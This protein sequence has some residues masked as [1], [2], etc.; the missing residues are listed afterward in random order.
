MPSARTAQLT[1]FMLTVDGV[2][3][4]LLASSV[5]GDVSADVIEQPVDGS[6]FTTKHLGP[7]KHEDFVV[8]FGFEMASPVYDWIAATW[9]GNFARKD[10]SV[11]AVD[12]SMNVKSEQQFTNALLTKT[13]IPALDAASKDAGS[14]TVAISP[15]ATRAAAGS[16]KAPPS[17]GKARRFPASAFRL[18]LDGLDCSHVTKI[19]SFTVEVQ[20]S[21]DA[22]DGL[23]DVGNEPKGID[24]PNLRVTMSDGPA[25]ATW[26]S[27]FTDFVLDGKNEEA[28]EKNGAIVFLAPDLQGEVA[29][30][31][32]HNVGIAAL[33]QVPLATNESVRRLAADLYCERMELTVGT[34]P[35]PPVK[36]VDPTPTR[37]PVAPG[38]VIGGIPR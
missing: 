3:C 8:Q 17:S 37:V 28:Q 22:V 7:L 35:S 26:Q 13:T 5:G 19:D 15:E 27:W 4:G 33:R 24:F 21:S 32:L 6:P 20:V 23:R 10:G 12:A 18:E 2:T 36:I 38:K 30:V 16:G 9:A 31:A 25:A 34:A 14:F 29:R 11:T 1:N